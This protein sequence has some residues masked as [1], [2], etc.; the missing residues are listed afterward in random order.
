M[1]GIWTLR[2]GTSPHL[3]YPYIFTLPCY[4]KLAPLFFSFFFFFQYLFYYHICTHF[5]RA[6]AAWRV[7]KG[8]HEGLERL[9]VRLSFE[10][11]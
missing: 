4:T 6:R 1:N 3:I 9:D 10:S 2:N 7:I 8:S 5:S 11:D